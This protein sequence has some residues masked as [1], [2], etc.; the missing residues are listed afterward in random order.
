MFRG[1]SLINLDDKGRLTIP[2]RYRHN[3]MADC[4]GQMVCTIDVNQPCLLLYPLP[5]WEIVERKLQPLSDM[6]PQE[7]RLKRLLMGHATECEMDKN[8]R[9]LLSVV[10][11]QR[12]NLEKSIT[13]VGKLNKFEIWAEETWS[14][15][16]EDDI[17]AEQQGEFELTERLS[18]FSL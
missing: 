9:L 13:L 18:D 8:G 6:V 7:R 12:V 2:S 3:L 5:Q 10:L 17:A 4:S 11:R 16:V 15:Q 14:S 1:A